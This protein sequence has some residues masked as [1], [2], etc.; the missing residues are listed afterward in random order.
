[1]FPLEKTS[2][3]GMT[4]PFSS[5]NLTNVSTALHSYCERPFNHTRELLLFNT[6]AFMN[7][8]ALVAIQSVVLI[9]TIVINVVIIA[10]MACNRNLWRSATIL[11]GFLAI[12]DAFVGIF[13][14]P[15]F[16][17]TLIMELVYGEQSFDTNAYCTMT[18]IALHAGDLGIGWSFITISFITFER[19]VA[20]FCPFW[21]R[22]NIQ[23]PLVVKTII[24]IWLLWFLLV[25]V[26]I[27]NLSFEIIVGIFILV[28]VILVYVLALPVYVRIVIL[29]NKMETSG[30]N[31][32]AKIDRKGSIT[33][34]IIVVCLLLC[35]T[36]LIVVACI[37]V[38]TN[39]GTFISI[40]YA[41]PWTRLLLLSNSLFNPIIYLARNQMIRTSARNNLKKLFMKTSTVQSVVQSSPTNHQQEH[42][43]AYSNTAA[44]ITSGV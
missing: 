15:F 44:V 4:S 38:G 17:T 24:T 40:T 22:K 13:S 9:P 30:V 10:A 16:L 37:I 32:P 34:G 36:P 26:L 28:L 33:C 6:N 1:M 31:Q 29:L 21:Y 11:I 12:T 39:G 7:R 23:T 18:K 20:I 41:F 2:K 19:Y 43:N 35:Y 27:L 25:L 5:T 8:I 14:M 42:I 3:H